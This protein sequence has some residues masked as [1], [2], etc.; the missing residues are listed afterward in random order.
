M[1]YYLMFNI[2]IVLY[3]IIFIY[4]FTKYQREY[5]SQKKADEN[6]DNEKQES[7]LPN[8]LSPILY[9]KLY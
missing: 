2:P 3:T 8:K 4:S 6:G 1:G 9:N 5:L 7:M